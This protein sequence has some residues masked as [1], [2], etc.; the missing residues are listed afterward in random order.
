M[1]KTQLIFFFCQITSWLQVRKLQHTQLLCVDNFILSR[2]TI[3]KIRF[4]MFDH[5]VNKDIEAAGKYLALIHSFQLYK[6]LPI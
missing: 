2:L 4:S 3:L 6:R 5:D 1:V